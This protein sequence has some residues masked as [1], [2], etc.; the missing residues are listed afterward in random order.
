[1]RILDRSTRSGRSIS[2]HG[3]RFV[4]VPLMRPADA[5]RTVLLHLSSGDEIGAHEAGQRQILL[6]VRGSGWVSGGDG[7]RV[8]LDEDQ[9]AVFE[10]GELHAAGTEVGMVV[11]SI[12][13]EFELDA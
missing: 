13:G 7:R 6:V 9:A 3:S 2:D 5:A 12:E 8:A 1:V 10:A 11:V 4:L